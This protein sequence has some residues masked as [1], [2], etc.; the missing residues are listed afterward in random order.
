MNLHESAVALKF[1]LLHH[2]KSYQNITEISYEQFLTH[3]FQRDIIIIRITC[4]HFV[5]WSVYE[6]Y[7]S[8]PSAVAEHLRL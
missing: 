3:R 1:L 2:F 8:V 7:G 4:V 6:E 5:T